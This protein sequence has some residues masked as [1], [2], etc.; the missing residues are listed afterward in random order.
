MQN[1][2]LNDMNDAQRLGQLSS[3]E[4]FVRLIEETVRHW[5]TV[6]EMLSINSA[7]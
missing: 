5:Y 3:L 7:K 2:S 6:T 1:T 4:S